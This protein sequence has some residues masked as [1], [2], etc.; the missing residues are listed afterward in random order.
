M[1]LR[2]VPQTRFRNSSYILIVLTNFTNHDIKLSKRRLKEVTGET[3]DRKTCKSK[4]DGTRV[5]LGEE[6]GH[7]VTYVVNH[8][9]KLDVKREDILAAHRIPTT[10][11]P[12]PVLSSS[13]S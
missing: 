1:C 6:G 9:L 12:Y 2:N 13:N 7:M 3:R 4:K 5:R 8:N 11:I 10:R